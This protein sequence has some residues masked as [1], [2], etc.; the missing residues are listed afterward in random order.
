MRGAEMM[1]KTLLMAVLF[2]GFFSALLIAAE[3]GKDYKITAADRNRVLLDSGQWVRLIGIDMGS[4]HSSKK[5]ASIF[6]NEISQFFRTLTGK[7]AYLEFDAAYASSG[8]MDRGE[9]LAYVFYLL[10]SGSVDLSRNRGVTASQ[11]LV[12]EGVQKNAQGQ[13]QV[14]MMPYIKRMLNAELLQKGYARVDSSKPL[15]YMRDLQLAER[16]AQIDKTGIWE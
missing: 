13:S 8:N 2:F 5:S 6:S 15:R 4:L 12:A 3:E 11:V 16:E 10:P 7:T 1:K 14:M 9:Q